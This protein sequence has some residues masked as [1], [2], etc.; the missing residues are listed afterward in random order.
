MASDDQRLRDIE[1]SLEVQEQILSAMRAEAIEAQRLTDSV[2]RLGLGANALGDALLQVDRNQQA[3]SQ[4]G[5]E[6]NEID[7][8]VV[9]RSEVETEAARLREE[10]RRSTRMTLVLMAIFIPFM[11]YFA[12]WMHEIYRD[13]C[14]VENPGQWCANVF[15]FDEED[16]PHDSMHP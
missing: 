11:A 10:R 8:K 3:L 5:R 16:T 4:L 15:L 12:I 9:P 1:A 7:R 2:D 14:H 13:A 6:M